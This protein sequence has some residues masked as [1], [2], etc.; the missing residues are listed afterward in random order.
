VADI[1][2][3]ASL[4]RIVVRAP[5]SSFEL[6][7]PADVRV[8]DL[9]PAVVGYAGK[10]LYETGIEHG[11]WILQRLGGAPLDDDST[12]DALGLHDGDV[13]YLRPRYA[14]MPPIHFDDLVDGVASS[15]GER[16][17]SWRPELSRRLL[18]AFVLALLGT[19]LAVLALPG[20]LVPRVAVAALLAVLLVAGSASAARAVGDRTA[21]M[22]LATAAIPFM[23][24]A[25]G[26]LPPGGDP[27]T[28]GARLLA[29]GAAATG[30]AA[31]AIAV[32]GVGAPLFLS[33]AL[34]M[35]IVA[36]GGGLMLS[37]TPLSHT[38]AAIAVLTVVIGGLVPRVCFRLS[39]LKLPPL[40]GNSGQ[41]QEG[42]EPHEATE[43]VTRTN[44]AAQYVTGLYLAIG[45][46]YVGCLTGLSLSPGWPSY[47]LLAVLGFLAL[48]HGRSLGGIAHRLAVMVPGA[49][50]VVLFAVALSVGSTPGTRFIVV[51][52]AM[53]LATVLAIA[54]WSVPGRR[55]LPHW[56]Q[57]ANLLHSLLA[58]SLVPLS[59]IEFGVFQLM[60]SL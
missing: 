60:R 53:A 51:A 20:P 27:F 18:I 13:L 4:C 19:C 59:L 29:G 40:P 30:M 39:G 21:G 38:T 28:S 9:L 46:I 25:A 26:L 5:A 1:G 57:A 37:G 2:A 7:I 17:D 12:F 22:A 43:V 55:M 11:G 44:I 45:A 54:S 23:A 6:T 8:I 50:G 41:L 3:V 31:V 16:S 56:G 48:L 35:L 52:G 42:I 47:T 58:I 33:V 15:L 36:V 34:A 49:Y 24:L 32:V 14:E 10:E